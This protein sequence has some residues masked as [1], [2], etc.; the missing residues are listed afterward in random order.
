MNGASRVSQQPVNSEDLV[1]LDDQEFDKY[2]V[3]IKF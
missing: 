3:S 2:S 1:S